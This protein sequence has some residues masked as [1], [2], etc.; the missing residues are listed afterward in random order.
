MPLSFRNIDA[1]PDD[2]VE[3]WGFEGMLAAIDR[4]YARDW[5]KLVDA[6]VANP[7]LTD[8]FHEAREAAESHA[9]VALLDAMLVEARRTASERALDRLRDA[10]YGTR[11]T[12]VELASVIGTS[13]TRFN[14]YLTGKV[15]PSMDV[16]VAVEEIALRYRAPSRAPELV[17]N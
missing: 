12:Q 16:L 9:T 10:Y 13:R 8:E 6:V 7:Q 5:R 3:K 14:S 1:T 4:G 15:T 17:L 2:P 11:M